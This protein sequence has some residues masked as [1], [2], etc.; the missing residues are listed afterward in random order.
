MDSRMAEEPAVDPQGLAHRLNDLINARYYPDKRPSDEK[1]AAE[2]TALAGGSK[3]RGISGPYLWELRK[4][5]AANPHA[6][7]LRSVADWL[8]CGIEYLLRGDVDEGARAKEKLLALLTREKVRYMA[9]R[10]DGLSDRSID[11]IIA[12]IESARD[13]E[14][15]PT[16]DDDSYSA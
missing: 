6:V 9:M 2:I 1:M 16:A 12:M 10:A 5:K 13:M 14:G 15:L 8:G 4:G 3:E 11:S 7:K